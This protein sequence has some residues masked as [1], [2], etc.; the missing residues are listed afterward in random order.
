MRD[1]SFAILG[2]KIL[3]ILNILNQK[4]PLLKIE[5]TLF[6]VISSHFISENFKRKKINLRVYRIFFFYSEVTLNTDLLFLFFSDAIF[7]TLKKIYLQKTLFQRWMKLNRCI[8][9]SYSLFS[10]SKKWISFW[11]LRGINIISI[12]QESWSDFLSINILGII[13]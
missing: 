1:S 4:L 8:S 12:H 11:N 6:G 5:K 3:K 10:G 13:L 2:M 7:L 9:V